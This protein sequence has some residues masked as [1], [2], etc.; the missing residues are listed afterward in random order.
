M[1]KKLLTAC[2]VSAALFNLQVVAAPAAPSIDWTPQD[3]S[4][5]EVKL[6]GSGS[7]KDLVKAKEQVDISIKWNSWSGTGG[8]AYK[9]Y[10]DDLLVE[11]GTL[12]AGT[13]AGVINFP[14]SKSGRHTLTIEL[15]EGTV[16]AKSAGKPIVI[17]DT[18]GAH[19][20]P[21]NMNI[22]PNNKQYPKQVNTV[23]GAYFVE[24][25][26]YG[27]N[28]DVSQIP[29]DNLTHLLYGF[30]PMCGP[31]ESLKEV[32]NGN[33]WRALQTACGGSADYEVVIHD[34]WAAVQKA[35]PGIDSK[36][37]IR[38]TYAQLMALKQRNPDLKIL[39]SVGGW[40]LSDPFYGFTEK[41]NRDTFVASMKKFLQT[42]KFYDG[43]DI[44]WEFPGGDGASSNLGD[45]IKDGPA[46][47]ALMQELRTM[48]DELEAQTGRT[49][50]LT[51]AIGSGY[52]KIEDVDY[53][54]ASQYMDYI[55]AMTYDFFGGW[56]NV[57][58]HQTGLNCGSHLSVGECDGTGVDDDGK[59]RKGPAYT[60][61]N[62]VNLLLAQGV[63]AKQIVVGAAMYGRGW[64]GV[65]P[66]N[67]TDMDNPMTAP[68]NG[69]LK[70]S[71]SEGVWE[72]G[73]MDYKGIA[74][75]MIGSAGTGVNGFEVGYDEVAQAAYVWNRTSGKLLTYDNP[76]SVIAKGQYV[77]ANEL[78]GLFAWE[79]DADN[80]DIL[81]AMH[82]GLAGSTGPI[83]N[84]P[85]ITLGT[86][87]S[88]DAGAVIDISATATDADSTDVLTYSWTLDA[89]LS[90][91]GIDTA[92]VQ[93]TAGNITQT[94][95]YVIKVNVSDGK[96][97][98]SKSA[99][100]KVVAP[101]TGNTAPIVAPIN[102]VI[103]EENKQINVAVSATDEQNDVLTYTW[104][105]PAGLVLSGSGESVTLTA[106][107]VAADT[108]YSLSV[109][110][111]D[112]LETSS[113]SFTVTVTNKDS[114][115]NTTWD[116]NKTYNTGDTVIFND[117]TYKAKWWTKGNSPD[118]GG[119]WE[120]VVPDD[121]QVRAW[122]SDLVYNTGDKVSHGAS[123]YQAG[124]WT[125]NEEPGTAA[126]WSKL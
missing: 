52:D 116:V 14:Y 20:A 75:N 115:G 32:E 51:S 69:K 24:W 90:A 22:D 122:R 84:K 36:D 54:A 68:G 98:V 87:F 97:T 92:N 28:F 78:G 2:A 71:T 88:V 21:L 50:E 101:T 61:T 96:D 55:F 49:Y 59:P 91:T 99:I 9:V 67:A 26:I 117:V 64:E 43:V 106:N 126:V 73:I 46:Y 119:P 124:W 44:D 102:D 110:V 76:R 33:S 113:Q 77:R 89:R 58:G 105:V 40:T 104:N 83:N 29:V 107:E 80:G 17:A 10:F 111:F 12:T 118:L 94:T 3:Y 5:V 56:N 1:Y 63:A 81:N 23:V 103:V 109:D 79:I 120:E 7:Y 74:K 65:Y 72:P 114:G 25:G 57:T 53:A 100:L 4:F 11:E 112:G 121:G 47:L 66:A 13:K 15:C 123:Q 86:N 41:A 125:K 85:V 35:L 38:G 82:E 6:D 37:P 48:L 8:D 45:P 16:C 31:N 108:D 93:I 30:I 34:P 42:W 18:D 19:L 60:L 70:G 95:D 62:A 27:R 39:P